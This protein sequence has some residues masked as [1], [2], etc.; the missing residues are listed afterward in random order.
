MTSAE[1]MIWQWQGLDVAWTQRCNGPDPGQFATVL[2]HGFGASKEHWRHNQAVLAA[3]APCYAIDLLG[4]GDSSQPQARLKHEAPQPGTL[5]YNFETW[6]TQ[7]A[8]FCRAVA[9][10]PVLL[11]GNSIGG[12]VAL[13]AAQLLGESCQGVVLINC[14][15]RQMDDKR[16]PEQTS[17]MRWS[18][19]L[20]KRM[21]R[22]R[23]LSRSLFR[24][25]AQP[26]V[27]RR[28]LKQ[29]YPSGSH[30]DD[31]LVTLLHAPTQRAGASEAFHGFI[32]LFDD[33]LAPDLMQSL[34]VPVD[35]IWGEKDPWESL[36]EANHWAASFNCI[37]SL[38]VIPDAGHCPHDEAPQ[39][40]NAVLLRILESHRHLPTA[41]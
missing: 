40:V 27:I 38:N 14:A 15:Q 18:R 28:L 29:A 41:F 39:E 26:H 34:Q 25:A 17:W 35:L 13:R 8:D 1:L 11:I 9:K 6:G 22:Q 19:P 10:R 4:F 37:R 5:A 20:L 16:L 3:I 31:E 24:N 23:W 30:V 36:E 33:H 2:I 21:V 32:N 7:V 12:G